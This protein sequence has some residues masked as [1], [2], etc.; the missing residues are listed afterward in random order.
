[1]MIHSLPNLHEYIKMVCTSEPKEKKSRKLNRGY[2]RAVNAQ[3]VG[4]VMKRYPFSVLR[5]GPS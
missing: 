5:S 3:A 4:K 2:D 1:M